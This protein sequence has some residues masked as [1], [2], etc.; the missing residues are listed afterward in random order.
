MGVDADAL[1]AVRRASV[2]RDLDAAHAQVVAALLRPF[3]AAEGETLFRAGAPVERL[4]LVR[5]GSA[6]VGDPVLAVA[7]PG[8]T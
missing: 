2:F 6:E 3:S 7:G 4:L 8:E 5:T 1:Q